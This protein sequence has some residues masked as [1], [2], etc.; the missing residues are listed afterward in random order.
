M[1]RITKERSNGHVVL[2]LEGRVSP[3]ALDQLDACWRAATDESQSR[4]VYVDLTDAWIVSTAG[5]DQLMRM[6]RA[7]VQ[8]RARGCFMRELVKEISQS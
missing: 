4:P 5:R 8:F 1:F 2:K 7:G 6:H 3:A